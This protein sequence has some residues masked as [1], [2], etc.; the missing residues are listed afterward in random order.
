MQ[1]PGPPTDDGASDTPQSGHDLDAVMDATDAYARLATEYYL[2]DCNRTCQALR[3]ASRRL[4]ERLLPTE[5][6]GGSLVEL[7]AGRSLLASPCQR[8]GIPLQRLVISDAVAQ[9]LAYSQEWERRGARL[10]CAPAHDVPL[11]AASASVIVASLADPYNTPGSWKE[12]TRLLEPGGRVIFTTPSWEW[13]Q[14]QRGGTPAA[15]FTLRDG[16]EVTAPSHVPTES[17]QREMIEREGLEVRERAWVRCEELETPLPPK[18]AGLPPS[19]P[20]VTAY[21]AVR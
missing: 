12:I 18:L 13:A 15:R 16:R 4:L 7:G 2:P 8:A 9:M 10:L 3:D 11:P 1:P 19:T 14:L 17:G 6:G 5:P 20:L 21:L